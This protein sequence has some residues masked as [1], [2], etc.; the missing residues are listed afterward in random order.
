M[1]QRRRF[2]QAA[3]AS[4]ACGL[5]TARVARSAEPRIIRLTARRFTYEPNEIPLKVGEAVVVEINSLDFV[6]GMN[7][8]DL[9][10]RLDLV[11]GRITRLE[12]QPTKPGPIDFVC[13]N[14][15]GDGHEEMHGRFV[16]T[17]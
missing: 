2:V 16:V 8:P 5:L 1:M 17:A 15:C 3:F 9:G 10:K 11:P 6:H 13:D 12:L 14:F 7:I 4:A